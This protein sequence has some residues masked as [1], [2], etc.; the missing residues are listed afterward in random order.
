M[1]LEAIRINLYKSNTQILKDISC[2]FQP[3]ILNGIIGVN[4]SGKS[5]FLK[6]LIGL[7][8]AKGEVLFGGKSFRTDDFSYIPQD[9]ESAHNMTVFDVVLLGLYDELY[10]RVNSEQLDK[11]YKIIEELGLSNLCDRKLS[12]LSGGQR[13]MVFL[14]QALVKQP[15]VILADEP[16]SALD[17]KNQLSYLNILSRYTEKTSAITI[18]VLHDLSLISRFAKQIY[19]IEKG[20]LTTIGNREEV[21]KKEILESVYGV[22]LEINLTNQGFLS[23]LPIHVL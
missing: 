9:S 8:S 13:Q 22:E 11:T 20:E 18:I 21:I 15:K 12:T 17:L 23:I 5:M 19:I 3:G 16:I 1:N 2:A 10:W 14:A 6:S 4:G 7:E